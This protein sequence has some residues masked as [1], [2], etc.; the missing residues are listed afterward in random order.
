MS[1]LHYGVI[2]PTPSRPK[3][4]FI[5]HHPLFPILYFLILLTLFLFMLMSLTNPFYNSL[6]FLIVNQKHLS[7]LFLY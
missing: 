7:L 4:A 5:L 1:F 6:G 3:H 2:S